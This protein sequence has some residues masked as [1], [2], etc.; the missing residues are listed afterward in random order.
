[1]KE[2]AFSK[3]E[4]LPSISSRASNIGLPMTKDFT[5]L[6]FLP[7]KT[8]SNQIH[9][10]TESPENQK[11]IPTGLVCWLAMRSRNYRFTPT[12]R[13]LKEKMIW[14]AK[15]VWSYQNYIPKQNH[16]VG[17][18]VTML[19]WTFKHIMGVVAEG[20]MLTCH[21]SCIRGCLK[22]SLQGIFPLI[23]I[24]NSLCL[25]HNSPKKILIVPFTFGGGRMEGK[26]KPLTLSTIPLKGIC[27]WKNY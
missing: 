10:E 1:M 12:Y 27:C 19:C 5:P 9:L 14:S 26:E 20:F 25:F 17:I 23:H 11:S 7:E 4:G 16:I 8:L 24:F 22:C 13:Q 6:R 18:W 21:Q 3:K 15:Q 2:R